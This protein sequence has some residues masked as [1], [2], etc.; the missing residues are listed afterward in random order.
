[1]ARGFELLAA[2]NAAGKHLC[3]GLDPDPAHLYKVLDTSDFVPLPG[4]TR[5]DAMLKYYA[6]AIITQAGPY[7][8]C[9]KFNFEF[10]A[11]NA[12]ENGFKTLMRLISQI[13]DQ[14]PQ[15]AVILDR[16]YGDISNTSAR[17]A[18]FAKRIGVDIVTVNPYM[19]ITDVT[20]EFS[21]A[22][23][24]C[25]VLCRTSNAG[26]YELQSKNLLSGLQL[27]DEVAYDLSKTR[28]GV[29]VGATD[30]EELSVIADFVPESPF[31]IPGVGAQ[32]GDLEAVVAVMREH[33]GSWIVNV[34][35]GIAEAGSDPST[36]HQVLKDAALKYHDAMVP[37]VKE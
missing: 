25:F 30:T 8:A 7:A 24:D 3:V 6:S 36:W 20:A 4:Q 14:Y 32:G 13:R 9:F 5:E 27:S 17:S 35:R 10:W 1:M 26:A 37:M 18:A 33:N 23:I 19:S 16:K 21:K 28:H 34:G 31:L 22:D 29:V 2:A 12:I 15:A 11:E